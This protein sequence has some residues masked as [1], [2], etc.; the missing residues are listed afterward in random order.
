VGDVPHFDPSGAPAWTKYGHQCFAPVA[1]YRSIRLDGADARGRRIVLV[2]FDGLSPP[3]L[4]KDPA[5]PVRQ[6]DLERSGR[7]L[8]TP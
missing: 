1:A 5:V 2:T 7:P 6:L 8:F 3:E 4:A